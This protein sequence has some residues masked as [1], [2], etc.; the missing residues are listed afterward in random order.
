MMT[1]STRHAG[2]LSKEIQT[3]KYQSVMDLRPSTLTTPWRP[4]K[5]K[6]K[7]EKR[8][9][10]KEKKNHPGVRDREES[11]FDVM[12][13]RERYRKLIPSPPPPPPPPPPPVPPA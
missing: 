9:K 11:C 8:K 5:E 3:R 10:K 1:N 4:Q 12:R 7:K 13:G 2:S 6:R